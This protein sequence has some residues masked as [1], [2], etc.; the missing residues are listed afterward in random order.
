M[1]L[2]MMGFA[3]PVNSQDRFAVMA[4]LGVPELYNLGFRVKLADQLQLG[5]Y[6]GSAFGMAS[7]QSGNEPKQKADAYALGIAAF[8]HFG[9][10]SAHTP[11]KPWYL[12]AGLNYLHFDEPESISRNTNAETRL[13]RVFNLSP[14]A[15]IEIDAGISIF[16]SHQHETK[17]G[18]PPQGMPVIL[19]TKAIPAI[20][21]RFFYRI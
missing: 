1:L 15:G 4:G 13:A 2:A 12:R 7:T 21:L 11:L 6:I 17:P 10:Q 16:L 8:Y 3:T 9:G 14:K 19:Q 18:A 20:G 5:A